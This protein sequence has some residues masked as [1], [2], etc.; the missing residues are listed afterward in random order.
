MFARSGDE[1]NFGLAWGWA[2]EEQGERDEKEAEKK[3]DGPRS[4]G[5]VGDETRAAVETVLG[6]RLTTAAC[7]LEHESRAVGPIGSGY[8][9]SPSGAMRG[10]VRALP[11]RKTAC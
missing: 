2:G 9:R 8:H 7:L 1:S 6:H 3:A 4:C 5:G 10:A 11:S